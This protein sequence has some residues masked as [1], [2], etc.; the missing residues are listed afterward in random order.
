[1]GVSF[2]LIEDYGCPDVDFIACA[3]VFDSGCFYFFEHN[4]DLIAVT[5]SVQP[6]SPSLNVTSLVQISKS[7]FVPTKRIVY[8]RTGSWPISILKVL[9][10]KLMSF[11]A[12]P[13]EA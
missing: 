10:S 7:F 13:F 9:S 6:L 3:S 8:E 11:K 4:A 1:M 12:I 2:E 5:F